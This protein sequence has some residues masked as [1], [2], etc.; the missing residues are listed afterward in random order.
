MQKISRLDNK[1]KMVYFAALIALGII[2]QIGAAYVMNG[3]L[4]SGQAFNAVNEEYSKVSDK[5][6]AP[7]FRQII[8]TI[9]ISPVLEEF[10]FRFAFIGLV[11]KLAK[12]VFAKATLDRIGDNRLFWIVNV[13]AS[14]LFG[15][16]HFNIVQFVYA[17]ILGLMLGFIFYKMGGYV[18]SLMVHVVINTAGVYLT[19]LLPDSIAP[20]AMVVIG[21]AVL[22]IAIAVLVT[23]YYK[24]IC[25][26]DGER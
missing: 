10:V 24:V 3:I 22:I 17:S 5:L 2:V 20:M 12:D 13:L 8:Q 11:I 25:A 4:F 23:T 1:S 15:I 7:D 9:L 18:A 26:N 19:P 14:I 6:T 21:I 16:Y